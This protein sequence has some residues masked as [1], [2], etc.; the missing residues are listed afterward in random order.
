VGGFGEGAHDLLHTRVV[1]LQTG[2]ATRDDVVAS[3]LGFFSFSCVCVPF[4]GVFDPA[5][6]SIRP[7]LGMTSLAAMRADVRVIC[8]VRGW[9]AAC[10][11]GASNRP[12][13][14]RAGWPLGPGGPLSGW[15]SLAGSLSVRLRVAALSIDLSTTYLSIYPTD[16][17]PPHRYRH[18]YRPRYLG[19]LGFLNTVR[20]TGLGRLAL[21]ASHRPP[22]IWTS[23]VFF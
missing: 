2:K 9:L 17:V 8:H 10:V 20:C 3:G 4:M 19:A 14:R 16:T 21:A 1:V 7:H 12:F 22:Q 6:G 15:V 18:W 23:L 11:H 13:G 5:F